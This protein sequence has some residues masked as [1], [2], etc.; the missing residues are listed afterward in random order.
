MRREAV[1]WKEVPNMDTDNTQTQ[2]EI[3]MALRQ[4]QDSREL[5][6]EARTNLEGL[7]SRFN[8]ST[9]ARH[10]V[11]LAVVGATTASTLSRFHPLPQGWW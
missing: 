3:L 11:T 2:A 9:V 7:L 10:A 4:I 8:L 6:A 5:Q 1:H